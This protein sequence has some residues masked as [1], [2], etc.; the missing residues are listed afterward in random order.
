VIHLD[1]VNHCKNVICHHQ[2][3]VIVNVDLRVFRS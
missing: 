3:E 2:T 1:A